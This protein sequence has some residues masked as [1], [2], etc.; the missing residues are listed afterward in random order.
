MN[1]QDRIVSD[2]D[3][4]FSKLRIRGTR[5]EDEFILGLFVYGWDEVRMLESY[6]Y[7]IPADL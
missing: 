3:T 2:P 1:W 7:L 6:P 5:I 4:L